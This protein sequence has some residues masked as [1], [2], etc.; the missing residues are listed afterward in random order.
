[1]GHGSVRA[2]L[3]YQHATTDRDRRIAEA[4]GVLVDENEAGTLPEDQDDDEGDDGPDGALV[5][6][7]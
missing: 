7:V 5:P 6:V 2:A 3:I 1:M 4:L